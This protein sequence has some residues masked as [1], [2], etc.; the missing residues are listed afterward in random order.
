MQSKVRT[1]T[2]YL[3]AASFCG[4]ATFI[5]FSISGA[6]I[7][8]FLGFAACILGVIWLPEVRARFRA[9]VRD[10]L[11]WVYVL[12]VVTVVP[13]V[14]ISE[15]LHRALRELKS[16]WHFLIYFL[17]AYNLVSD[18]V[19]KWAIWILFA[20]TSL[21]CLVALIQY[22]GGL[23]LFLFRIEPET[24]R[25]SSTL[26]TMT[27]AGILYQMIILF[28]ALLL[29]GRQFGRRGLLLT[30]GILLQVSALLFTLTRGAWLGLLFG[31]VTLTIILKR[32]SVYAAAALV[33][34]ALGVF[35]TVNPTLRDRAMGTIEHF[36]R[37]NDMNIS[38][39]LVL[40]DIA[41]DLFRA[42]P[43]LG[44][45][46]GDYSI[47]AERSLGDRRVLTTWD[48]HNVY[49]HILATRGLVGFIPFVIFWVVLIRVLAKDKATVSRTPFEHY[50]VMGTIG[51]LAALLVGALTENNIDDS[52]VFT[53][54]LFIVG[55]ARSFVISPT[56]PSN[57]S[58]ADV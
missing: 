57:H 50:Y 42:N 12:V 21:S 14:I 47:E 40:W 48:T 19:R 39:R 37:P 55:I 4:L 30:A 11:F 23:D 46:I 17:V 27:F 1:T 6:N 32:K 58:P 49:L 18:R 15:N 26:Y 7:S 36:Q 38:T 43:I 25:P 8:I 31:L 45:G 53:A 56:G 20:S 2:T 44:V 28:A 3:W 13:S 54:F 22:L 9:M 5:P 16:Q 29:A 41:W 52:E 33:V 24:F 35:A 51:A 34:V 10:P